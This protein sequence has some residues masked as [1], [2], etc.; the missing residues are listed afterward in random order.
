MDSARTT[1][2]PDGATPG[3][4]LSPEPFA[5]EPPDRA[6]AAGAPTTAA[7]APTST[8]ASP[9]RSHPGAPSPTG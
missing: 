9:S 8:A 4:R 6:P 5:E 1:S 7:T 2:G 3:A